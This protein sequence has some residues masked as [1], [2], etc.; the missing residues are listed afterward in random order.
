VKPADRRLGI[1]LDRL[2]RDYDRAAS[3]IDPIHVVRRYPEPADREIAGFCASALA[4][5]RV[6]SVI[7]TIER[8]LAPMG[9]SPAAFIR[10]FDP[11]RD[12]RAFASIVHRWIR[13][14]DL[15]ALLWVL[16][17]MIDASGT[18]E[19]FFLEGHDESAPDVAPALESF[20]ARALAIDLRPVY[21]R[22]PRRPGVRYFFP[23]PSD[24]SACKRLNLFLRW[25]VRR[26]SLDLGVWSRVSP[27]QLVVPL[28]THVIRVGR[29]LGLTARRS[30]G[31]E[32][33][34][35]ITASLRTFDPADPVR[36]D[37]SLCHIGME[38]ACGFDGTC[39]ET[40]CPLSG[41]CGRSLRTAAGR[42]AVRRRQG[43][44][45]PS[46]RR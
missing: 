13:G 46:V 25:M 28:D 1:V 19:A 31:W 24:G 43:S 16:R 14:R 39:E 10:R 20:S 26:D 5:G 21:G 8:L 33:A 45:Q 27:A 12:G 7:Q 4:F 38:K 35:E 34:A 6:A 37:F 22:V 3:A 41:F 9:P 44:R 2:Y 15:V 23:R 11:S 40:D 42:P 17:G 36:F 18:L 32:M 29:G 30:P